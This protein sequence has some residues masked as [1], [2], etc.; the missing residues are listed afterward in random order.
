MKRFVALVAQPLSLLI[1]ACVLLY[2]LPVSIGF[3]GITI[4]AAA[5][6]IPDRWAK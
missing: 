3:I 4:G 1:L 6:F 5:L 2:D